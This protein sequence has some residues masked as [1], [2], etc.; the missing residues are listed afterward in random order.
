ME[1]ITKPAPK[2]G[3][4]GSHPYNIDTKNRIS[5]S[6]DFLEILDTQYKNEHR[7]VITCLSLKLSIAV[8]PQENYDH[9]LARL[10]EKSILDR[11]MSD[12]MTMIEGSSCPQTIDPQGRLRLTDELMKY[13]GIALKQSS[14]SDND[15]EAVSSEYSRK[16]YV[17]GFRDHFEIWSKERWDMFIAETTKNL[18]TI[19]DALT[20]S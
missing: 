3:F 12:L 11:N 5:V 9:Y 15:V 8:Y 17:K 1:K 4:I 13:A 19:Q 10:Q 16:V 14:G 7:S 2:N 18:P 6:P 20:R